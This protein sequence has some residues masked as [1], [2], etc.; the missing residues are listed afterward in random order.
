LF[1]NDI[2]DNICTLITFADGQ[3]PP[4]LAGLEALEHKSLPY[5]LYFTFNNSALFAENTAT[6][7]N[8]LSSTFWEMGMRSCKSFFDHLVTLQTKSL[9][10]TSEVLAQ[11][12]RLENTVQHLYEEIDCGLSKIN[13]LEQEIHIFTA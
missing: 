5:D 8:N 13:V 9:V 3:T 4:V 6:D 12:Q 11:R 1:G 10:L 2:K 7:Q